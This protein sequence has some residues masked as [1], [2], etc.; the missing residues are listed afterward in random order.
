MES[1]QN[2][3]LLFSS[4]W[5]MHVGDWTYMDNQTAS[6]LGQ[7]LPWHD[8]YPST[9]GDRSSCF[10][11]RGGGLKNDDWQCQ[12]QHHR[13]STCASWEQLSLLSLS[14][15]DA[16]SHQQEQDK[17]AV[18]IHHPGDGYCCDAVYSRLRGINL[19]SFSLFLFRSY[20]GKRCVRYS[21]SGCER[22]V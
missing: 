9:K 21:F 11:W 17:P 13:C 8:D 1:R 22:S 12:V 7:P 6:S 15:R 3:R 20:A 10:T 18:A 2:S 14:Y 19:S 4:D 5:T 16:R